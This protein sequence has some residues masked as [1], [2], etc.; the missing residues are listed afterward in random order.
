MPE[1]EA[2]HKQQSE[3]PP[4]PK[5]GRPC[6]AP[7]CDRLEDWSWEKVKGKWSRKKW[8]C[9]HRGRLY[10]RMGWGRGIPLSRPKGESWGMRGALHP[11]AKLAPDD[12]RAA[13]RR[14]AEG[15]SFATLARELRVNE[16]TVRKAV[17]FQTWTWLP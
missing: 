12:V 10:S 6:P 8:C 15:E 4:K 1:R 17:Q 13:R 11:L 16:S 2:D 5:G 3:R 9:M 14:S 7:G